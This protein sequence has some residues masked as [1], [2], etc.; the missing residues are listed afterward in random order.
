MLTEGAEGLEQLPAWSSRSRAS[1]ATERA[2]ANLSNCRLE[3]VE[4]QWRDR[5]R[6]LRRGRPLSLLQLIDALP[7]IKRVSTVS[8]LSLASRRSCSPRNNSPEEDAVSAKEASAP[9]PRRLAAEC[10]W[11]ALTSAF[12]TATSL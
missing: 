10:L 5:R 11:L 1:L 4:P 12:S 9:A 6:R 2:G 3:A 7:Q 8:H